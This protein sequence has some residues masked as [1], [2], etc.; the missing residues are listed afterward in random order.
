[1]KKLVFAGLLAASF[2][3]PA[4]ATADVVTLTN[5][6]PA[7]GWSVGSGEWVAIT[8]GSSQMTGWAG[9]IDWLA[10]S[11]TGFQQSLVTYCVDLFNDALH[12]QTMTVSN[13]IQSDLTSAST[14]AYTSGAGG[15]AAWLINTYAADASTDNAKAAGL[16]IAVWD[17]MYAANTFSVSAPL[18][19]LADQ[20]LN[21]VG[22]NT[23]TGVYYDPLPGGGQGQMAVPEPSAVLLMM[24][25]MCMVFGYQYRLKRNLVAA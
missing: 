4:V 6:G 9:E 7:Y 16:Q 15:R 14:P 13:D 3:R 18:Q 11:A 22:S 23:S 25:G 10:T 17:T 24:L 19:A 12:S 5:N 2:L 21:T 1:M 20:Y 8:V